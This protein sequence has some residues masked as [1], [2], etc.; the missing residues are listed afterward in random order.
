MADSPADNYWTPWCV[1]EDSAFEVRDPLGRVGL[2]QI[3]KKSFLVVNEFRFSD[4]DVI[5]MLT[6][7]L[8]DDG[9]TD[10]EAQAAVDDAR[11]FTP[12]EEN[13]TDV[14][15]IPSYMRWFENSYGDHTLAAIIHDDLIVDAVNGGALGS[16]TLSDRFFREMMKSAGV[17]WLKRWVMWTA[18]A[19]RSRWAAGG[20]RQGSV[21][22]WV[23]M[24]AAGIACFIDAVGGA[25]FDWPQPVD[26][27]V[28]LVIAV[29]LPFAS[30]LLWGKQRGA[31]LIAAVA[32]LWV[33]PAAVF[34][35]L[36]WIVYKIL[37]YL[38]S[39]VGLK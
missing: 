15:S 4:P 3:N 16:D 26:T 23:L 7:H 35:V 6:E 14:A 2:L 1:A 34:G 9:M 33:L 30:T 17:P 37:E 27:W 29:A 38:A 25:L 31:S 36:A 12:T 13:P 11:T 8:I 19:L 10:A 5:Q 21:I 22:V 24:A 39:K 28:L 20:A 32:A 18:V